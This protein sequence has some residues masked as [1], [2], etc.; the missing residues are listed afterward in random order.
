MRMT[1]D[2]G[3]KISLSD[4]ICQ[5]GKDLREK[6]ELAQ[7]V[8]GSAGIKAADAILNQLRKLSRQAKS[9]GYELDGSRKRSEISPKLAELRATLRKAG[10]DA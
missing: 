4:I 3:D 1:T 5:H 9:C 7:A 6:I 10:R 8:P 2:Q